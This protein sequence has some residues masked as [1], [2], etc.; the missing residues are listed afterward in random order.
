MH[1]CPRRPD[2]AAQAAEEFKTVTYAT[3]PMEERRERK[4]KAKKQ[5]QKKA[6]EWV[7]IYIYMLTIL[8]A[9]IGGT[10]V[11]GS[12]AYITRHTAYL[13]GHNTRHPPSCLS[14]KAKATC[15]LSH[16]TFPAATLTTSCTKTHTRR[17][18]QQS[19]KQIKGQ[20]DR[21]TGQTDSL[22]PIYT[23]HPLPPPTA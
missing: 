15:Q 6:T 22:I 21:W 7:Y 17:T 2:V 23:P 10:E 19:R 9:T 5:Q 4:E 18:C 8:L 11:R 13:A 1:L 16:T 12:M 20:T 3:S 14:N